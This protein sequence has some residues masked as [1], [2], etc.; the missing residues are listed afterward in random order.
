MDTTYQWN[1]NTNIEVSSSFIDKIHNL[2]LVYHYM[3]H[4]FLNFIE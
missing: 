4:T 3:N 1:K 2:H